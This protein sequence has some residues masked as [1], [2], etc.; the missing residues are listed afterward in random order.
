MEIS[1]LACLTVDL[2]TRYYNPI[3]SLGAA[4]AIAIAIAQRFPTGSARFML[5]PRLPDD[6]HALRLYHSS[7]R[8]CP[9]M[10]CIPGRAGHTNLCRHQHWPTA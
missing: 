6:P 5:L 8:C 1:V 4:L 7:C 3:S 10:G 2:G 9:F